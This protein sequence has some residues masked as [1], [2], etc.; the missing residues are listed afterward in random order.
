MLT[1]MKRFRKVR[2]DSRNNNSSLWKV[3]SE[4][5]YCVS[6]VV[7][8]KNSTFQPKTQK[9]KC[10]KT[11]KERFVTGTDLEKN[12]KTKKRVTLLKMVLVYRQQASLS[13]R[14]P[15]WE[16][17]KC[18]FITVNSHRNGN[19]LIGQSDSFITVENLADKVTSL[20][21]SQHWTPR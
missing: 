3:T 12:K 20:L 21:L 6:I 5:L 7:G 1:R 19:Q 17:H 13:Y 2:P 11:A 9:R 14:S 8:M 4:C 18:N 16:F 15:S 10:Y